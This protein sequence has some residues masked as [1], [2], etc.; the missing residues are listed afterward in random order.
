MWCSRT[1]AEPRK[2]ER[3]SQRGSKHARHI[4]YFSHLCRRLLPSQHVLYD[5]RPTFFRVSGFNGCSGKLME[6]GQ[7]MFQLRH[8][9][10]HPKQTFGCLNW[11]SFCQINNWSVN[12]G[13]RIIWW[14]VKAH[15]YPPQDVKWTSPE[16]WIR[17]SRF[18]TSKRC[19]VH[20][21]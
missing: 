15:I 3:F 21:T 8:R 17:P 13:S 16:K 10:Y 11:L 5:A 20:Q 12:W 9:D 1:L 2:P 4:R 19:L 7:I 14:F 6:P 18:A